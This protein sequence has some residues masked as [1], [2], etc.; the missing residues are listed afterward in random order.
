[1]SDGLI[2]GT[3]YLLLFFIEFLLKIVYSVLNIVKCVLISLLEYIFHVNMIETSKKRKRNSTN[4]PNQTVAVRGVIDANWQKFLSSNI[5]TDKKVD[6]LQSTDKK[7]QFTGMLCYLS[8]VYFVN[9]ATIRGY[10]INTIIL[11][12]Y[13]ISHFTGYDAADHMLAR[14]SIVNKFGDCIYDKF[15]KPREEVKDYRTEVSG[16]RREDLLNG[17]DFTVVQ[18]EVAELLKGRILVGHSL[19]ND[20]SVLFLSHPKRNIRD[21]SRYKPFRECIERKRWHAGLAKERGR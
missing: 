1:M 16:V 17:E 18:K 8:S 19:K 5:I 21:T 2:T 7:E 14:V 6:K 12:V 10:V 20:L 9:K 4:N 13:S 15:V 11:Q 3:V